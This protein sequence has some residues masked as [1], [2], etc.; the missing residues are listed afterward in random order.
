MKKGIENLLLKVPEHKFN[1][2]ICIMIALFVCVDILGCIATWLAENGP[3]MLKS[4]IPIRVAEI[5]MEVDM[6]SSDIVSSSGQWNL[7]DREPFENFE[8]YWFSRETTPIALVLDLELP[9]PHT[10]VPLFLLFF[11]VNNSS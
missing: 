9:P 7:L 4:R 11:S 8:Q 3:L 2:Y 1:S 10:L 5:K 6:R